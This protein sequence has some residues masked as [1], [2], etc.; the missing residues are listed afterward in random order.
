M[1]NDSA[2]L[3]AECWVSQNYDGVVGAIDNLSV[4]E[5]GILI[6]HVNIWE[7]P[8]RGITCALAVKKRDV[9][10]VSFELKCVFPFFSKKDEIVEWIYTIDETIHQLLF[11]R[12]GDNHN[13][14]YHL[15]KR[16]I[17]ALGNELRRKLHP[18]VQQE[19]QVV[20][21]G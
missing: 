21:M 7:V 19:E 20:R 15:V 9:S 17:V 16:L 5:S 11:P 6:G 1:Q 10:E 12:S 3:V 4:G 8:G 2:S 13:D 18:P 14:K